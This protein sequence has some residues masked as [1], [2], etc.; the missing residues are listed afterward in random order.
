MENIKI[1]LFL[2][3]IRLGGG[4][5]RVIV[6]LAR[7]L[8]STGNEVTII[9]LSKEKN[10]PILPGTINIE[11]LGVSRAALSF[12]RLRAVLREK[13]PD[14]LVTTMGHLN[15][16][17]GIF[18]FLLPRKIKYVAR[19]S[20][21]VTKRIADQKH[22]YLL[23]CLYKL[24]YPKFDLVVCQSN[25]MAM[26]LINN[27]GISKS[28]IEIIANPV[29]ARRIA[30]KSTEDLELVPEKKCRYRIVTVGRHVNQKRFDLALD[31]MSHL[32]SDYELLIIGDGP[33]KRDSILRSS[34]L[35]LLDRVKFIPFQMNPFSLLAS[36]DYYLIT[37]EFEGL[38]NSALEALSLGIPVFGFDTCGGLPQF[39]DKDNGQL[40]PFS[41]VA[42]LSDAILNTDLHKS[43]EISEKLARELDV[44]VIGDAYLKA[45]CSL[46]ASKKGELGNV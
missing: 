36:A 12:F 30:I 34:E 11:R 46:K 21:T 19:E 29:D 28:K 7:E 37:S 1:C 31:L 4:A 45:L 3:T 10:E 15:L 17:V 38:P 16:L 27:Y 20:N 43:F 32:G 13:Q 35:G 8:A 40:V 6:N 18:K 41:D 14:V 5:A 24:F 26:D 42:S 22:S 23:K 33:K 44:T 25:I 39:I 9:V 2:P